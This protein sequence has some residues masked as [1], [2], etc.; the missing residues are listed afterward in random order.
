L[1]SII[2]FGEYFMKLSLS[3]FLHTVTLSLLCSNTLFSIP[4]LTPSICVLPHTYESPREDSLFFGLLQD[5]L[6][7]IISP[8]IFRAYTALG[9]TR[10]FQKV[11][12]MM[13]QSSSALVTLGVV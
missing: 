9:Y 1:A 10:C 2:I 4:F 8:M 3:N 13:A 5:N 12:R 7:V 6:R 11:P